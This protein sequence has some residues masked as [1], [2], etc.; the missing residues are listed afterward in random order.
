MGLHNFATELSQ[1]CAG[2]SHE[3]NTKTQYI[4]IYIFI[5]GDSFRGDSFKRKKEHFLP[6]NF[7]ILSRSDIVH[8]CA[9][10]GPP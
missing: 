6:F 4:Y 7:R 1:S 9:W 8:N 10:D 2:L 5:K 3:E